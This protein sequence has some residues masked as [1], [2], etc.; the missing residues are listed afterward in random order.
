M[1]VS[2]NIYLRRKE[3]RMVPEYD[4]THVAKLSGGWRAHFDGSS[5][6]GVPWEPVDEHAPRVGSMDDLRGYL[7]TGDWE[8]VDE[9]GERTTLERVLAHDEVTRDGR[10]WNT[11]VSPDDYYDREGYPW[12][13]RE[14]A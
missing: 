12:S 5:A 11:R 9:Y 2:T 13:R 1:I 6:A 7:D 4:E 10:P 8:L 14:F 3:P